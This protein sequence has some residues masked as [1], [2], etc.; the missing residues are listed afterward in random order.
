MLQ[1]STPWVGALTQAL[2]SSDA[3][4]VRSVSALVLPMS[5]TL[6]VDWL[7]SSKLNNSIDDCK[8]H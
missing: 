6:D 8:L 7:N 2:L 4:V 5:G 3:F 1:L